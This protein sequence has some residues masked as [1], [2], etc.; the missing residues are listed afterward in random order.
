MP[1]QRRYGT[2]KGEKLAGISH[3]NGRGPTEAASTIPAAGGEATGESAKKSTPVLVFNN[4]GTRVPPSEAG[5]SEREPLLLDSSS[6]DHHHGGRSGGGRGRSGRRRAQGGGGVVPDA[7]SSGSSRRDNSKLLTTLLVLNYMIGSGILNS[8]QVFQASGIGLATIL[9]VVSAFAVWLG[10]V[11]LINASEIACPR[12]YARGGLPRGAAAARGVTGTG[13][14]GGVDAGGGG[15][16][17]DDGRL[18]DVEYAQLARETIGH[19]GARSVDASIVLNNFGDVCSY[20]ILVGSLT[21]DLLLGWFGGSASDAWW[22]SFSVVTP[23]MAVLFVFPPCLVRHFS[24]LRWV[25]VFSFFAITSVV[26]LVVIAGP[27]YASEER[28]K[29][30]HDPDLD[31]DVVWWNWGGSLAKLGSIVFALSSAP[32]VLHAYTSMAPRSTK[33]WRT[34]ASWAVGVGACLCY[35][36]G[37]AGYLSFRD[38]VDGDILLNLT[39]TAASIF[40]VVVVVHLVLYIPSEV[41]VMRHSLYELGGKDVMMADFESVAWVTF[42]LLA[43]I[44]G[45]MVGLNT[46][47]VAQ[48]DLFGYILDI[49]GGVGASVTSFII[50]GLIYLSVTGDPGPDGQG[51]LS[52]WPLFEAGG[53]GG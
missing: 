28:E 8:P 19:V 35:A 32:A 41:I 22:A 42:A 46:V 45:A 16:G 39:G 53:P 43:L 40:K 25:A 5:V 3:Y 52:S 9:F 30:G 36:M 10:I 15:E 49:T 31:V 20:V 50:P 33:A 48:G 51:L 23:V 4:Y 2:T 38:A 13:D 27:I 7:F 14:G 17:G 6:D 29:P 11:V 34:V 47:G 1:E 12:G 21:G 44:V 18:D 24:N 26:A 37:L